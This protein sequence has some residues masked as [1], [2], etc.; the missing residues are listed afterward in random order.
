MDPMIPQKGPESIDLYTY[1]WVIWIS[2]V[3][4]IV[5]FMHKLLKK[6]TRKFNMLEFIGQCT[7]SAFSGVIAFWVCQYLEETGYLKHTLTPAI[8]GLAG[9]MG[10][11]F[12]TF[13]ENG[14]M[15]KSPVP[16]PNEE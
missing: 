15:R 3:G 13:L 9:H 2:T 1:A 4:G 8:V 7:T 10:N 12:I 16:A 6:R 11:R 14:I 5:A